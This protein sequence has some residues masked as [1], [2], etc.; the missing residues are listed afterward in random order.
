MSVSFASPLP[1][2]EIASPSHKIEV[3]AEGSAQ[4]EVALAGTGTPGNDRDFIL[5]YR[6]SG[7]TTLA[8]LTLYP[9]GPGEDNYF[10]ALVEPPR[11]IP[12]VQINPR[13]YVFVVDIS[14][15]MHGFPLD[16]AKTLLRHL[17]GNL[18][19]SDAFNVL[20]FSGS[21]RMLSD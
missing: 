18:R 12:A 16:T 15:S 11:S 19:A 7:E 20:L 17:I 13:E 3:R 1:V 14:G 2:H 6:T 8:G 5:E 9:G 21:N 10:L 4:P